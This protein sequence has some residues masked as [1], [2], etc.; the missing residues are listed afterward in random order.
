[1]K[2]VENIK[3]YWLKIVTKSKLN[4]EIINVKVNLKSLV[5]KEKKYFYNWK[6]WEL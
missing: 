6:F 1:M 3:S 4:S 2:L 5:S